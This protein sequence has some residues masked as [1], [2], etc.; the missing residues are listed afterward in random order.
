MK[1]T[2]NTLIKVAVISALLTQISHASYLFYQVSHES[3]DILNLIFSYIF[4]ISLELSI[5]IFT[6]KGKKQVA[7]F[8]AIISVLVNLLYYFYQVGLTQ[9]FLGMIVISAIVPITIWFYSDTIHEELQLEQTKEIIPQEP[10]V[11]DFPFDIPHKPEEEAKPKRPIP[12]LITDENGKKKIKRPVG[13]PS[14]EQRKYEQEL[15]KQK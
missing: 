14:K 4:A 13:K 7:T 2:T 3:N 12:V 11:L 5:Y 10:E 1:L 9:Q 6:M 8:F 15:L